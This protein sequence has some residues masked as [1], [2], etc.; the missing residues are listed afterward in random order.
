MGGISSQ[1]ETFFGPILLV[2]QPCVLKRRKTGLLFYL[3]SWRGWTYKFFS[4]ICIGIGNQSHVLSSSIFFI[5]IFIIFPNLS[6]MFVRV[7][8]TSSL[9]YSYHAYVREHVTFW[10]FILVVNS[11]SSDIADKLFTSFLYVYLASSCL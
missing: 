7:G 1:A 8:C 10:F 3:C 6:W 4:L 2:L 9:L 5:I 11:H